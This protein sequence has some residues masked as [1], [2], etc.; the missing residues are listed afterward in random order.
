MQKNDSK[1]VIISKRIIVE[2]L[3]HIFPS[4]LPDSC[5]G[6][7]I[8]SRYHP[9]SMWHSYLMPILIVVEIMQM[10]LELLNVLIYQK[11]LIR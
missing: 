8:Y 1:F 6:C 11:L 7:C 3:S 5:P 10:Y 2:L 4:D 9:K